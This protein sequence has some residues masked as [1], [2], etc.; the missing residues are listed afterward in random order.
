MFTND[1]IKVISCQLCSTTISKSKQ[2]EK[3]LSKNKKV[4]DQ[5]RSRIRMID[6]LFLP[7]TWPR[8]WLDWHNRLSSCFANPIEICSAETISLVSARSCSST[9]LPAQTRREGVTYG[10]STTKT[11]NQTTLIRKCHDMSNRTCSCSYPQ[12]QKKDR[13]N[14]AIKRMILVLSP[15]IEIFY[16]RLII[17]CI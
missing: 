11:E 5:R 16:W 13:F 15:F 4:V 14:V 9:F 7:A 10:N 3:E 1:M 2:S 12:G 17:L 6:M 8:N